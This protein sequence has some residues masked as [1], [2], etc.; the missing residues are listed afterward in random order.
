MFEERI[1]IFSGKTD[2]DA[3]KKARKEAREYARILHFMHHPVQ[4]A[5]LQDGD[6]LIDGYEVWSQ[7]FE[8]RGDLDAF[9]RERYERFTYHVD[10]S[11][12]PAKGKVRRVKR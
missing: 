8:F 3:F 10:P 5:Y 12:K 1:C 6:P 4:E 7:L 11:V 2:S 9:V